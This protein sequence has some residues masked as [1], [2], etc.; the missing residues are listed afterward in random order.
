M[1]VVSPC[2]VWGGI[3]CKFGAA[4]PFSLLVVPVSNL[5]WEGL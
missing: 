5:A 3:D 2:Q 1:C 4:S